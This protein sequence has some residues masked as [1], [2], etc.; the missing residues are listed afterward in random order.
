MKSLSEP[1]LQ[2]Q[3]NREANM[4][5]ISPLWNFATEIMVMISVT[6]MLLLGMVLLEKEPSKCFCAFNTRQS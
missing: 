6:F 4:T 5:E 3:L 2:V 1:L